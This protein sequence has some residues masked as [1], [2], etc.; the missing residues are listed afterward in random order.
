MSLDKLKKQVCEAN[1]ALERNGLVTLTWGNVSGLGP[2]RKYMVI[3]PSGVAYAVLKPSDMVVV[4]LKS[5]KKV[6]GKNNPS[7]DAPAHLVIYR[8]FGDV[9]GIT[10]THSTFAVMFAQ[11]Q[12]AI[13]AMGTTHADHF[14]GEVPLTRALTK[15]EVKDA[16]E[17]HTGNVIVERFKSLDPVAVPGVLVANHGPFTWGHSAIDSLNNT[18][19]LEAVAKMAFGTLLLN[20]GAKPAPGYL[21]NKH[22]FRKH[23]PNAY[24]GQGSK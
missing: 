15:K 8:A 21:L 13:P 2:A 3:K 12:L 24:Y 16:Y 22:Y 7:S 4:D 18:I 1:K 20:P 19:A 6:E 11:A 9:Y 10:H 5:G 23:G 14:Y 17:I